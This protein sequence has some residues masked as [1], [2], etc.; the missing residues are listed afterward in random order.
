MQKE[1]KVKD[2]LELLNHLLDVDREA[3][4]AL[5]NLRVKCNEKVADHEFVQ[6]LD[7]NG[8]YSVG[9][10][11]LLNGLFGKDEKTGYGYISAVYNVNGKLLNFD[12]PNI[13]D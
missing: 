13:K 7:D 11:G 6:V 1:P 3:M 9:I 8:S 5:V 4:E 12:I 2:V 10:L